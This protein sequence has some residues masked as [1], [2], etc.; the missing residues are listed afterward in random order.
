MLARPS[1]SPRRV[2]G[3]LWLGVLA[4]IAAFHLLLCGFGPHAHDSV[5][6]VPQAHSA[7]QGA[8]DHGTHGHQHSTSC[9]KPFT[10][11]PSQ[12]LQGLPGSGRRASAAPEGT[13]GGAPPSRTGSLSGGPLLAALCVSR[14]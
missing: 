7:A 4:V 12:L 5:P 2:R 8:A 14:V 3:R 13:E 6:S 9:E 11:P 1:R 10:Q